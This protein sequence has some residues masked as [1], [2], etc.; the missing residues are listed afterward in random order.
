M[1]EK[2]SIESFLVGK[3][4]RSPFQNFIIAVF[5]NPFR[6]ISLSFLSV[7]TLGTLLLILPFSSAQFQ[8]TSPLVA[9]FTATSATCVT[10]LVLVDTASYWSVF[11]ELVILSLIQIGGL[12]LVTITSFFFVSL[13]KKLGLRTLRTMQEAT[14][15]DSWEEASSLVK[16]IVK[17]TMVFE[18]LGAFILAW[19]FSSYMALPR[20]IYHGIFQ[21]ISAFCNAGFDLNGRIFGEFSSLAA[22]KDDPVILLTTALL[23][24]VGGLGFIVWLYLLNY[25]EKPHLR[26][27]ARLVVITTL[28]FIVVGMILF[29]FL[30]WNNNQ[31][32]ALGTLKPSSRLISAFFQSVTL[33]TAGFNVIN[34]T[35][36]YP[37]SKF[38]S[39]IFMFIGAAPASTAGGIK[40]TTFIVLGASLYARFKSRDSLIVFKY[41]LSK[42]LYYR[43]IM[44]LC[45]AVGLLSFSFFL[46]LYF[47]QQALMQAKLHFEDIF[48]EMI[49]AFGTVGLSAGGTPVFSHASHILLIVLMYVGRIGPVS[50]AW[51]AA[52]S[53]LESFENNS[54]VYPEGKTLVG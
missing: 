34:Q 22:F 32:G 3:K 40:I 54:V 8:F 29:A 51:Q 17:Y 53:T 2:L 23:V 37:A 13:G 6:A 35:T 41:R 49:S 39:I 21:S 11:G 24:I 16:K 47:E 1:R 7:I 4:K 20:A 28:L 45:M 30:E 38:L 50:F 10:G 46:L 27:H 15:A 33:R 14:S 36:L 9:L 12:G 44:I 48:F 25:K 5:S 43:A 18:S 26:F 31:T 52:P 42:E 19:R